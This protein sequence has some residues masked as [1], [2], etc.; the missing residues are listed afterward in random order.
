MLTLAA[1]FGRAA[2]VNILCQIKG[3][4]SV[5]NAKVGRSVTQRDGIAFITHAQVAT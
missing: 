4:P 1:A 3:D 5:E 2:V